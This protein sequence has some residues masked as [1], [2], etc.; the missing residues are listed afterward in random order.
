MKKYI[1]SVAGLVCLI[2]IFSKPL[3]AYEQPPESNSVFINYD[4]LINKILVKKREFRNSYYISDSVK[5]EVILTEIKKY[6]LHTIYND[7]FTQWYGTS[8]DFNGH[9]TIPGNGYIACGYFVTTILKDAGFNI[10][11]IK[12]A[13]SASEVFIKKLAPNDLKRFNN[14]PMLKVEEHLK[15]S[16]NELYVVGLDNHTGFIHV[17]GNSMKFIHSNYYE[18]EIGVM[19]QDINDGS[20]LTDSTYRVIGKLFSDDMIINWL[21]NNKYN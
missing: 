15:K 6:L 11:R 21:E 8:W 2:L 4:T 18:P 10:P 16:K 7:L 5:K 1:C 14:S 19:A 12:W 17:E 9:T 13:Q 20:P 3:S